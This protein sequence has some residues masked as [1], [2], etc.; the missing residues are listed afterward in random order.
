MDQLTPEERN[1]IA[2]YLAQLPR[3]LLDYVSAFAIYLVP[4]FLFALYGLSKADFVA[5][6]V[7]YLTLLIAIIYILGYQAR[8]S[9]VFYSAIRKLSE[10]PTPPEADATAGAQPSIE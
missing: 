6:A 7:A 9:L 4:S 3:G 2:R 8:R 10:T 1:A 5:V